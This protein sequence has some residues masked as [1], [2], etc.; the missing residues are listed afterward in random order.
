MGLH[1]FIDEYILCS[2]V[3]NLRISRE[4]LLSNQLST[5]Y[6]FLNICLH[7]R[8]HLKIERLLRVPCTARRSN[9]LI[10]KEISP[11]Q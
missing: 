11:E 1:F 4:F 6:I 9:H 2:L 5:F 3:F 8:I 10:L 7:L